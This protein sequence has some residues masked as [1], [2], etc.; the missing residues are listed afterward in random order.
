MKNV[1]WFAVAM[2]CILLGTFL[3]GCRIK[4]GTFAEACVELPDSISCQSTTFNGNKT[5]TV[6]AKAAQTLVLDY[7]VTIDKG[8]MDI[9]MQNADGDVI[10]E[11]SIDD[12]ATDTVDLAIEKDGKYRVVLKGDSMGGEY[13]VSWDVK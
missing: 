6:R 5:Y 3:V 4:S 13:E 8:G 11:T 12:A 2:L 9:Q 10:W 7:D 1:K